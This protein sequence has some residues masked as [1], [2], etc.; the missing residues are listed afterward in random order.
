[1]KPLFTV[2]LTAS[3]ALHVAFVAFILTH[4]TATTPP[5]AEVAAIDAPVTTTAPKIDAEVWSSLSGSGNGSDLKGLITQ[6]RAAGFPPELIRAIVAAQ[7]SEL[8]S[9]RRKALQSSVD[10]LPFWKNQPPDPKTQLARRQLDR[11]EQ[12]MLRDTLGSDLDPDDPLERLYQN[13]NLGFLSP[14]KA[15]DVRTLV[16]DVD[17]RRSDLYASG[18][19]DREKLTALEKEQHDRLAQ[20][21]TPAELL[22]YDLRNSNTANSLRTNLAAFQPTEQEFR[23]IYQLRA[24]FDERFSNQDIVSFMAPER[25]DAQKVL[26][27][28]I[29]A[30]LGP[31]R[32]ADYERQTDYNYLRT[33]QLVAR[34]ELP[35]QTTDSLWAAQK[36]FEQRSN[37]IKAGTRDERIQQ[38]AALQQEAVARITSLL[39]SPR[40]VDAYK[41]YGGQWLVPRPAPLRAP[42]N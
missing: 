6:L 26:T 12:K 9:A 5:V 2:A 15:V 11:E 32:A 14:E 18:F 28:Q 34:L 33:N 20:L 38:I 19:P 13:R 10:N 40:A 7:I 31:E 39:G 4:Q 35:P 17:E 22:E 24:A 41:L 3:L 36:E 8:F 29:K 25:R 30:A 27:E 1:M 23:T 16:R 37:Q 21:L 42:K